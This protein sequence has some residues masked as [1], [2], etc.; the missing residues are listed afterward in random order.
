HRPEK[1]GYV[2]FTHHNPAYVAFLPDISVPARNVL[3]EIY[4]AEKA[5]YG[6]EKHWAST[7]NELGL[8]ATLGSRLAEPPTLALTADGFTATTA[9]KRPNG[10][11]QRWHIRQDARVWKE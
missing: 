3:Q 10:V 8:P 11:V 2:Q 4:Y 1:W 7:L 9:I 6:R 5:F